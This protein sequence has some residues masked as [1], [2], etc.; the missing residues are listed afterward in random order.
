MQNIQ[1]N[2]GTAPPIRSLENRDQLPKIFGET[3]S[4]AFPSAGCFVHMNEAVKRPGEGSKAFSISTLH[5]R[6]ITPGEPSARRL[7]RQRIQLEAVQESTGIGIQC[8]TQEL[9]QCLQHG[10]TLKR[11]WL[12]QDFI[13]KRRVSHIKTAGNKVGP[14]PSIH[15]KI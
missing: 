9:L 3:S 13:H 14:G 7:P 12:K 15:I 6:A 1:Y 11:M 5:A 2:L 4:C 10:A 8:A